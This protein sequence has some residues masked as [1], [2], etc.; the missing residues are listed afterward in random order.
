MKSDIF[1]RRLTLLLSS[2]LAMG[3]RLPYISNSLT[4]GCIKG[5]VPIDCNVNWIISDS[6]EV[7]G[8][9]DFASHV[10]IENFVLGEG[11]GAEK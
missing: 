11:Q 5:D 10:N 3:I 6:G 9:W 1:F 2:I 4:I 8:C 7:H